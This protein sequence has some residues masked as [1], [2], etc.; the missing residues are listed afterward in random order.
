MI[1]KEEAERVL[2][3]LRTKLPDDYKCIVCSHQEYSL[4]QGYTS[5]VI[6]SDTTLIKLDGHVV[7]SA[8]IHCNKCGNIQKFAL[9]PLGLI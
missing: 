2:E 6:Q 9:Q 3:T 1:S 7:V 5:D 8:I 4:I